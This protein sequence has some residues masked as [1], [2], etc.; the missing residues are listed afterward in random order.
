MKMRR[1][2]VAAVSSLA[3]MSAALLAGCG[4]SAAVEEKQVQEAG[5]LILSVNPEIQIAYDREGR[6]IDLSGM[7]ADGKS[8]VSSYHDY[9]G[10]PCGDVLKE[11]IGEIILLPEWT[12][13]RRTLYFSWSPVPFFR[14]RILWG[15]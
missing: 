15:T 12:A 14:A 13:R 1:N 6:V 10:R 7:N 8:I 11:L 3:V 9:I 4:A 2:A 5:S